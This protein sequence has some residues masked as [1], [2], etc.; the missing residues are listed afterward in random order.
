[1]KK[2]MLSVEVDFSQFCYDRLFRKW[3]YLTV[4]TWYYLA[5]TVRPEL[6]ATFRALSSKEANA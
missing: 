4:E 5:I 2:F 6:R 1:M 3:K